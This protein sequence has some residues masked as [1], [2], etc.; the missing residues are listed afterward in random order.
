MHQKLLPDTFLIL[1]YKLK[2]PLQARNFF[3]SKIYWK[4]LSNSLKEIN[5]IFFFQTQSLLINSYQ[6]QKGS[7]TSDR[8]L[9]RLQN[10]S[11]KIPLFVIYYLTK[12]DDVIKSSF[13]VISKITTANL[14]KPIDDIIN[15]ST[16]ICPFESGKRG[17]E[18]KIIKNWIS[19]EQIE[20]F[21]WNNKH[22]S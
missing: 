15:Y 14:C 3:K 21:R 10:K 1:R 5:F 4:K 7:G 16:S 9:F 8:P 20:L 18:G 13:W 2:Q 17:K 19:R 11:G 12:F 22:F 6:K